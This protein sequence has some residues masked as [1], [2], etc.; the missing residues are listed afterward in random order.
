[1][2]PYDSADSVSFKVSAAGFGKLSLA[3]GDFVCWAVAELSLV[4]I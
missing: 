2:F 1:M 3:G 4:D